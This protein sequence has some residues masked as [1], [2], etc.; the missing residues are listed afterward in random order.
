LGIST[1]YETINYLDTTNKIPPFLPL[2]K[3][4]IPLFGKEGLGEILDE[5]GQLWI[6]WQ[7]MRRDKKKDSLLQPVTP[8]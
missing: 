6:H 5:Y 7:I 3:G 8:F 1:F 2:P 4:G